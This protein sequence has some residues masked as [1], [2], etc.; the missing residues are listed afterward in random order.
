[1]GGRGSSSPGRAVMLLPDEL[2]KLPYNITGYDDN[3]GGAVYPFLEQTNRAWRILASPVAGI[4]DPHPGHTFSLDSPTLRWVNGD[5]V[6]DLYV[7]GMST[8]QFLTAAGLEL[9][10]DKGGFVLSKR[11]SRLMRP[12][13]V[14]G[15]FDPNEV[16]ISYQEQSPDEAKVWDGAGLISRRMLQ[17][18]VLSEALD[19]ARRERLE[20]EL[21][22][23]RRVEFTIMTAKGQDKGHAIVAGDL[24]DES[25]RPVDFLLPKDTKHEIQLTNG[26][27]FVG[28]SVVHGHNDMRL[29]IQS[30]INLHPFFGEEQLLDW[31]QLQ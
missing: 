16:S 1:M 23:A 2:A 29:D 15:F 12:H 7:D 31:L 25:G 8:Q 20:A 17:K 6:S 19:P 28:I 26:K 22:H 3:R 24:R 21:R 14:S 10:M 4:S 13:F 5:R 27:T 11:L 30:L 18:M 9:S